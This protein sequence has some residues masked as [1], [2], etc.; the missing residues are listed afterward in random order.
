MKRL[1]LSLALAAVLGPA[2][3]QSAWTDG[4]ALQASPAWHAALAGWR[5]QQALAAQQ[6]AGSAE[7]TLSLS[8]AQR[9]EP[10]L[11]PASN[12]DLELALQRPWRLPGKSALA[13]QAAEDREAWARARLALA[14]RQQAEA[15][16]AGWSAWLREARSVPLLQAQLDLSRREA[17]ALQRRQALG[18]AAPAELLQAQAAQGLAEAQLSQ[19]VMRERSRAAELRSLQTALPLP[20]P[21]QEP[22]FANAAI[23][24]PALVASDPQL[25]LAR[26]EQRLLH[27]L[28]RAEQAEEQPDPVLAVRALRGRSGEERVLGLSL[29]LAF[30]GDSRRQAS[31]AALARSAAADA[32]LELAERRAHNLAEQALRA[33]EAGEAQVALRQQLQQA[34]QAHADKLDRAYALGEGGLGDRWLARRQAQDAAVALVQVRIDLLEARARLALLGGRLLPLPAI[35]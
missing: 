9:R 13:A 26:A 33:G 31:R 2:Q 29:S 28:A 24:L 19:A 10:S 8:A 4:T 7:W 22:A 27:A 1:L 23:E 5:E 34:L 21:Q 6:R 25:A 20:D 17:Q 32:A 12:Q 15:W 14:W 3:A 30:G 11:Q 18:D 35:D 16:L